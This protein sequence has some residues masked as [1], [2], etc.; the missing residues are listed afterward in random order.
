MLQTDLEYCYI[1]LP[2]LSS[3]SSLCEMISEVH[4]K[5]TGCV[6]EIVTVYEILE[7]KGQQDQ[8]GK[9]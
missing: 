3:N 7:R 4:E 6:N 5:F 9:A 2:I 8:A 1:L